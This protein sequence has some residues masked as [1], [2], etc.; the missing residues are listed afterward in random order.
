MDASLDHRPFDQPRLVVN[1][2]LRSNMIQVGV[3]NL[4]VIDWL[5]VRDNPQ[6]TSWE[7]QGLK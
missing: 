5:D 2:D 1:F 4:N 7:G 6:K 3:I